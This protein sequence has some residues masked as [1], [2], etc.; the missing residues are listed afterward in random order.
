MQHKATASAEPGKSGPGP[1]F[2]FN[3]AVVLVIDTVRVVVAVA[4]A[5]MTVGWEK[6]QDAPAGNPEQVNDTVSLNPFTG[7]I[8]MVA[9]PGCVEVT[10]S[11]VGDD[12]TVK[13]AAARLIV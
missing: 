3:F 7:T 1:L 2:V 9:V 6:V 13:S 4:F 8:D 5:T 12:A 10:V 11:E